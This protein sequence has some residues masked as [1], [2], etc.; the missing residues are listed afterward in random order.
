[1]SEEEQTTKTTEEAPKEER[2]KTPRTSK[3]KPQK[4]TNAKGVRV[5]TLASGHTVVG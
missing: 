3:A 4:R 5:R 2:Q 1:M